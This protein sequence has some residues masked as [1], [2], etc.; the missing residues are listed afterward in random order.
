MI[1]GSDGRLFHKTGA[2]IYM[3]QRFF[4]VLRREARYYRTDRYKC[5]ILSV[6]PWFSFVIITLIINI[7]LLGYVV[8]NTD[9]CNAPVN[10][11]MMKCQ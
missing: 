8:F 10:D 6:R 1:H 7:I 2:D 3:K 11:Y 9:Y 4:A 5:D